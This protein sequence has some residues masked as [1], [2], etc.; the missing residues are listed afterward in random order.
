MNG[1]NVSLSY[2]A[3]YFDSFRVEYV[4]KEIKKSIG[5]KK[6]HNKYLSN[7]AYNLIMCGYFCIGFIHFMF[8]GKH[9]LH[10]KKKYVYVTKMKRMIKQY[11]NIVS[12]KIGLDE[13]I[14]LRYLWYV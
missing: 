14:I 11:K 12:K 10:C 3:I 13:K 8:K 1:N 6:Y 4:P 7:T 9:L 5:I 2:D